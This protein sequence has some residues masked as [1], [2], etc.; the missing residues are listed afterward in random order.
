MVAIACGISRRLSVADNEGSLCIKGELLWYE[1]R[2]AQ[3]G[4]WAAAHSFSAEWTVQKWCRYVS[5]KGPCRSA[6]NTGVPALRVRARIKCFPQGSSLHVE[7][8]PGPACSPGNSLLEACC[9]LVDGASLPDYISSGVE[10]VK[11]RPGLERIGAGEINVVRHL[12]AAC[13]HAGRV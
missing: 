3:W 7:P 9:G 11:G 5:G 8:E 12:L 4:H 1:S 2:I 10:Q 13:P 6:T